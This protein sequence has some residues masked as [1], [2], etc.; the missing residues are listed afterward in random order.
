LLEKLLAMP[1]MSLL[2]FRDMQ[3]LVARFFFDTKKFLHLK[4]FFFLFL[5]LNL[6]FKVEFRIL[7][8]LSVP[9]K[10]G[11]RDTRKDLGGLQRMRGGGTPAS[12][13]IVKNS[14]WNFILLGLGRIGEQQASRLVVVVLSISCF[15]SQL[16]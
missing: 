1:E 12:P 4:M 15:L 2:G 6:F 10:N 5:G 9:P 16:R 3:L 14:G 7:F 13:N 11:R 8:L